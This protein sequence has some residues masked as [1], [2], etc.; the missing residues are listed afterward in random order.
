MR[1]IS[2]KDEKFFENVEYFSEIINSI[3][4]FVRI[5]SPILPRASAEISGLLQCQCQTDEVFRSSTSGTCICQR[6]AESIG[7]NSSDF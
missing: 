1:I 3:V 7:R 5:N 2:K 6:N 4:S